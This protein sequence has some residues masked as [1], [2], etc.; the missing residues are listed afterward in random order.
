[1]QRTVTPENLGADFRGVGTKIVNDSFLGGVAPPT[2]TPA[3]PEKVWLYIDQAAQQT[4]HYWAPASMSWVSFT[5]LVATAS[6]NITN[7]NTA[8]NIA[9]TTAQAFAEAFGNINRNIGGFDV[10]LATAQVTLPETGWYQAS[11]YW[12]MTAGT[13]TASARNNMAFWLTRGGTVISPLFQNNYV[14]DTTGNNETGQAISGFEF[15]AT[16]GEVIQLFRQR[17]SGQGG[18]QN[19]SGTNN[20]FSLR[21]I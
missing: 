10:N 5:G 2:S 12:A 11:A 7:T 15:Q 3:E 16:A 20:Y 18:V 19:L 17:V 9:S 4:T 1:M 21:R 13:A 6:L 8:T 14:R